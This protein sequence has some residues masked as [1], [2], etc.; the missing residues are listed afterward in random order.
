MF[1]PA[2][3]G[4]MIPVNLYSYDEKSRWNVYS[5]VLPYSK[6]QLV[7]V[8]YLVGLCF[9]M[10]V[11]VLNG[12]AQAVMC[13]F[14]GDSTTGRSLLFMGSLC[15]VGFLVPVTVMPLVIRCGVEKGRLMYAVSVG[16]VCMLG[17]VVASLD[18]EM[19]MMISYPQRAVMVLV[20]LLCAGAVAAY[21]V[22][23]RASVRIYTKQEVI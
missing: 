22:S 9:L 3:F 23:W 7:S 21:V 18:T 13:A 5:S 6:S 20:P 15:V 2:L 19:T 16:V 11:L 17:F 14:A 1:Y 8:K 12:I 4:G 10:V